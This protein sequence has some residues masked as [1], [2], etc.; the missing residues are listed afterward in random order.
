MYNDNSNKVTKVDFNNDKG[1]S[2]KA[3][4]D[5]IKKGKYSAGILSH[6]AYNF[7]YAKSSDNKGSLK[8]RDLYEIIT[9]YI[10]NN[11]GKFKNS[12]VDEITA[13]I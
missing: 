11:L 12:G 6:S 13:D 8:D 3:F 2:I 4:T 1:K 5:L 10:Q 7:W 9:K